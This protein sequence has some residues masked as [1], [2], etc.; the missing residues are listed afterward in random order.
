MVTKEQDKFKYNSLGYSDEDIFVNCFE[1][2]FQVM[3]YCELTKWSY[4]KPWVGSEQ[5]ICYSTTT[6]I[7]HKEQREPPESPVICGNASSPLTTYFLTPEFFRYCNPHSAMLGAYV[8][9]LQE[10]I[11]LFPS[12]LLRVFN[13]EDLFDDPVAI[14]EEVEEFLGIDS[15]G[16]NW[17]NI[18]G[19]VFNMANLDSLS[20]KN[21]DIVSSQKGKGFAIGQFNQSSSYPELSDSA[22]KYLETKF[23]FYNKYLENL[24]QKYVP[25]WRPRKH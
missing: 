6:K 12:S 23:Q 3:K 11:S 2:D 9:Q 18:A 7:I 21:V 16:M 19:K 15:V 17:E 22:R 4:T 1:Q 5:E 13:S 25:T 8:F 20:G 10:W 24:L 14:L